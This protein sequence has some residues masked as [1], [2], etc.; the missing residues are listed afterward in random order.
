MKNYRIAIYIRLSMEDLDVRSLAEKEESCSIGNQ[1]KLIKEFLE[2]SKEFCEA[3]I[4]EFVDA[5][6]SGTNFQRPALQKL[7]CLCRRGEFD[8][9]VVKD[10]SRFGRNYLEVGNYLEQVFPLLGVRFIAI[11]D[12][13]D[14][15]DFY[16]QTEGMD[17]AFK[18]FIYEMYSKD[19]SG[20]IKTGIQTCMERGDYYTGCMIYGYKKSL[21]K[22]SMVIDEEAATIIRRIFE[23]MAAGKDA[24]TLAREL[25]EEGVLTKLAYKQTKGEQLNRNN[26]VDTWNRNKIYSIVHDEV[27]TGDMIYGKSLRMEVGKKKKIKQPKENWIVIQNHHEAIVSRELYQKANNNIRKG[28]IRDYDRSEVRWG[29]VF[30]GCCK[31]RLQLYKTKNPY[32][33]CKRKG[34]VKQSECNK[35]YIDNKQLQETVWNIWKRYS[36][37]FEMISVSQFFMENQKTLKK[38]KTVLLKKLEQFPT[39]KVKLY[40]EFCSSNMTQDSFLKKKEILNQNELSLIQKVEILSKQIHLQEEKQFYC[41][42]MFDINPSDMSKPM[43]EELMRKII[44]K[45]IVYEENRIEIIWNYQNLLFVPYN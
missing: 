16:G 32:Y 17:I 9:I 41:E 44:G 21:D 10:L 42:K 39:E 38:H 23:D 43:P 2:Q 28:K 37:L 27:Y 6:Y 4:Q 45:I 33:L 24:K 14:S 40:E 3:D 26:K 31:N 11:N 1:R 36:Q 8:C 7:L 18:N 34:L 19:L 5:G 12:G 25:N 13:F 29:I 20:K 15:K 22:K 35:L 30:C